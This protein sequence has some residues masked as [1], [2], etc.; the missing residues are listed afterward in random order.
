MKARRGQRKERKRAVLPSIGSSPGYGSFQMHDSLRKRLQQHADVTGSCNIG[1]WCRARRAALGGAP[2][3]LSEKSSNS[4]QVN[5]P[6]SPAPEPTTAFRPPLAST[7]D[8]SSLSASV[9]LRA[10]TCAA[11]SAQPRRP[12]STKLS[13]RASKRA[14]GRFTMAAGATH[15]RRHACMP[16]ARGWQLPCH[17]FHSRDAGRRGRPPRTR[18]RPPR[19]GRRARWRRPR[20][21]L[22]ARR[23]VTESVPSPLTASRHRS[24]AASARSAT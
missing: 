9:S 5:K 12:Y 22:P 18:A 2:G 14:R 11:P 19:Q 23:S 4:P 8:S 13:L 10:R 24:L 21:T 6:R 15:A 1:S 3:K 7:T 17:R 16:Q 20:R